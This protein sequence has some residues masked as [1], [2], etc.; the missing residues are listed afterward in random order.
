M[1]IVT[2]IAPVEDIREAAFAQL[3]LAMVS[4]LLRMRGY[5][6]VDRFGHVHAR[7][8]AQELHICLIADLPLM[9]PSHFLACLDEAIEQ[10]VEH[11][12]S[13]SLHT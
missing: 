9:S 4:D 1:R 11:V 5:E 6:L 13:L 12:L 2:D 3:D 8:N 7:S 10:S